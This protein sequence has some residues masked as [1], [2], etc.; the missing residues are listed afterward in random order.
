MRKHVRQWIW[1]CIDIWYICCLLAPSGNILFEV[2]NVNDLVNA[3]KTGENRV[4]FFYHVYKRFFIFFFIKNAFIN[5]FYFFPNVYYNYVIKYIVQYRDV[6]LLCGRLC[7]SQ[8]FHRHLH[9]FSVCIDNSWTVV[10]PGEE[11]DFGSQDFFAI[12]W[13]H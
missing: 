13:L 5:V 4:T 8:Q 7:F 2:L 12:D 9:A 3:S 1:L 6:W 11:A 10:C